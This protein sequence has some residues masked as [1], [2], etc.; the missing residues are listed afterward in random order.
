MKNSK[1]ETMKKILLIIAVIFVCSG[2]YRVDQ[3]VTLSRN[4]INNGEVDSVNITTTVKRGTWTSYP[5]IEW[6]RYDG[7]VPC[8]IA[9]S[10]IVLRKNEAKK[11]KTELKRLRRLA[12]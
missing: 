7:D 11:A 6:Y 12:K 10:I 3:D 4:S 9:D 1:P 2:C 5:D 8:D